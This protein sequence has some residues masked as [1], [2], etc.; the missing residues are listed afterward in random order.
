MLWLGEVSSKG[1]ERK[2][3]G[4]KKYMRLPPISALHHPTNVTRKVSWL[5]HADKYH[6]IHNRPGPQPRSV[7]AYSD[8]RNPGERQQSDAGM[9]LA[10]FAAPICE[11]KEIQVLP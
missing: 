11:S 1:K 7:L 8:L 10:G 6:P 9:G 2:G 4:G 3:K 5:Y